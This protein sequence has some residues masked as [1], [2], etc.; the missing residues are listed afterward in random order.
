MKR[1]T[2]SD[3][4]KKQ[5]VILFRKVGISKAC[6]VVRV[7]RATLYRWNE[8]Y[9][10]IDLGCGDMNHGLGEKTKIVLTKE[11]K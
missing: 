2:Y 5:A 6:K 1:N 9:D 11:G 10:K 7:T 8:A 3:G 4:F